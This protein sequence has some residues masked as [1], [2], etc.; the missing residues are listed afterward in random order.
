MLNTLSKYGEQI[1]VKIFTDNIISSI[2]KKPQ[3]KFNSVVVFYFKLKTE[4]ETEN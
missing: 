1:K 4:T 3:Q 2:N